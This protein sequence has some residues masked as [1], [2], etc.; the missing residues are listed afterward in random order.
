MKVV[1]VVADFIVVVSLL[2]WIWRTSLFV[3]FFSVASS[4]DKML[5]CF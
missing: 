1:S 2:W 4:S 5:V 3:V